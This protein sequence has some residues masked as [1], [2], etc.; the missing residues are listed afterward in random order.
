MAARPVRTFLL[1][2]M[3]IVFALAVVL[4]L[5]LVVEFFGA[6][7]AQAWARTL[8]RITAPAVIRFGVKGVTT[9]Y[10]GAFDVGVALTVLVLLGV[11]WALGV[12]RRSA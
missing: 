2:I 1:V 3:D 11:E 8:L 10:G 5:R 12:A 6:L 7:S 4:V 9:P